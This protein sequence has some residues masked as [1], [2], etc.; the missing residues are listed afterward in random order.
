MNKKLNFFVDPILISMNC[1]LRQPLDKV[2]YFEDIVIRFNGVDKI[3]YKGKTRYFV[4]AYVSKNM[5]AA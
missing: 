4:Y 5:F 3:V 1:D 2:S